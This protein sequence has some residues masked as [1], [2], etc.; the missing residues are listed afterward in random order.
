MR[1]KWKT[2]ISPSLG[3]VTVAVLCTSS[4]IWSRVWIFEWN[5]L[6]LESKIFKIKYSRGFSVFHNSDIN[7]LDKCPLSY[8]DIS[9]KCHNFVTYGFLVKL[10]AVRKLRNLMDLLYQK[11]PS[12]NAVAGSQGTGFDKSSKG[13]LHPSICDE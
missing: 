9:C 1:G 10:P 13:K 4:M 7:F 3:N 5:Q 11:N 6:V 8:R 12:K 2:L